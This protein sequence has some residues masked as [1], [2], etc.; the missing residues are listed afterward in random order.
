MDDNDPLLEIIKQTN[1]TFLS[2]L[3]QK[4]PEDVLSSYYE[5]FRVTSV[6][7]L[8]SILYGNGIH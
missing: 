8:V 7:E 1:A 2:Q 6:D 4:L 5:H 3:L